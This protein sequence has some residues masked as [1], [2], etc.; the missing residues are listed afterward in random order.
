MK[1]PNAEQAVVEIAKLRDYCLNPD[2]PRGRNKARVFASALGMTAVHA[3]ELQASL[4]ESAMTEDATATEFDE[5]GQRY[6]VDVIMEG[7]NGQA[8]VRSTWIVRVGEDY[9]R[10]TSCYVL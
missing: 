2:H 4:L 1:L 8:S 7:P 10:L 3:D 9:P 6:V 5:F